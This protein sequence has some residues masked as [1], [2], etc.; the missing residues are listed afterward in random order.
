MEFLEG[1]RQ[2]KTSD[3]VV[4]RP[5]NNAVV[6]KLDRVIHKNCRG[7]DTDSEFFHLLGIRRAHIDIEFLPVECLVVR[8]VADV[9]RRVA[10]HTWHNS[11]RTKKP[12]P[13]SRSQRAVR[14]ADRPDGEEALV[15]NMSNNEPNLIRV[16]L[17]HHPRRLGLGSLQNRPSVSVGIALD[18]IRMRLDVFDPKFLPVPLPTR[19]AGRGEDFEKVRSFHVARLGCPFRHFKKGPTRD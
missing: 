9:D 8:F 7:A 1:C 15:V 2:N 4:E 11:F 6:L 14:P 3:A 17:E 5:A 13:P 19:G 16:G 12:N 10:N 18:A